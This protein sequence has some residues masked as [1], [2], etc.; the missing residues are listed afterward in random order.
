MSVLELVA[1]PDLEDSGQIPEVLDLRL[2]DR[3]LEEG[4]LADFAW[5]CLEAHPVLAR[6][7]GDYYSDHLARRLARLNPDRGFALLAR[8]MVDERPGSRWNPITTGPNHLALWQELSRYDRLRALSTVLEAARR[9][10]R[11]L[12]RV[13]F[14]LYALVDM[15]ADA[16]FLVEY[17]AG[18]ESEAL[19]ACEAV[20]GG[21]SGFWPI[22]CR[23]IELYPASTDLKA[24][25]EQRVMQSGQVVKGPYSDHYRGCLADVEQARRLPEASPAVV[26]WLEDFAIRLQQGSGV[27]AAPRGRRTG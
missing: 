1:G 13:Q 27:A 3:V 16:D 25:L 6:Y 15:V 26:A 9:E 10:P 7:M 23:L 17:A 12:W 4:P 20:T 5:R 2:H 21:R 14:W 19:I 11:V 8:C 18:G 22:A 24:V